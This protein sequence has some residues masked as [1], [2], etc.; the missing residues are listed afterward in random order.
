MYFIK[1][2]LNV[3]FRYLDPSPLPLNF[4]IKKEINHYSSYKENGFEIKNFGEL[5]K[6]K[7]FYVIK[8]TPGTGLFSNLLFVL[9]HIMIANK[10]KYIPIVDM[11]NY[12]TIYNEK[13]PI[14]NTYNAWEYYFDQISDHNLDEVYKSNKVIITSDKFFHYFEYFSSSYK[15]ERKSVDFVQ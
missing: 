4:F 9:N 11:K 15:N 3:I 10:F 13:N 2:I 14:K 8:R 12:I 5:N 1:K 6:D 7:T